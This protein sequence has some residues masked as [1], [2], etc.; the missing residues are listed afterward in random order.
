MHGIVICGLPG[1]A[2]F[3][4]FIS[5]RARFSKEKYWKSN[6]FFIFFYDFSETFL[7]SK[8]TERDM[9]KNVNWFS[10]KGPIFSCP[11]LIKY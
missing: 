4:H 5:Q 11:I 6:V 1:S 3:F 9:I 10:R 2:V 8:E 7:V